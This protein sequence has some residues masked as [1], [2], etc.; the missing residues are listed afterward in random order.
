MSS[1]V[2]PVLTDIFLGLL[3]RKVGH[4]SHSIWFRYVGGIFSMF[5]SK[6]TSTIFCITLTTATMAFHLTLPMH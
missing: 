4:A 5:D 6:D 1:P 3:W 2:D